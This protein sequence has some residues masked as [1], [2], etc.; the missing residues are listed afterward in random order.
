MR[1]TETVA[2]RPDTALVFDPDTYV[3]GVPYDAFARLRSREPVTWVEEPP[4][5]RWPAGPGYWAVW[6]HA[7]V[8]S[9]LSDPDLFSS[10]LGATQIRDPRT[11]ED[12]AYVRQS[13]LNMDPPG[14]SRLRG[15][16][17]RSFT[18][19]AVARLERR[20]DEQARR[21]VDGVAEAGECDFAKV[22]ADLPLSTLAEVLGV[23]E[24][25]RYLL[26]D[27]AS[28]VIGYQDAEYAAIDLTDREGATPMARAALAVRPRPDPEGRMPDP[29]TRDG[30]PDLYAYAHELAAF[31]RRHPGEDVMSILLH[32]VDEGGGRVS[33]SEFENMFW[34]FAVAGNET[35][36]NGMPGGM[37]ALLTFPEERA[38]LA[39]D[40]GLLKTG[41]EEMLRWWTPVIHFRRTATRDCE[42]AGRPIRA[43]DKVVVYFASANR[44]EHV[45][46]EPDRFDAG[47]TPNDHLAF[48]YGAHFCL[49]AHLA[50]VQMR[51]LFGAVL[52][53]FQQIELAGEV[54]RLRS[55]FQNGIKHLPIRWRP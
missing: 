40:R 45:F 23:P 20:I 1:E 19:R 25:D 27:W 29:R 48:G 24:S 37:F 33:V 2:E 42:L 43:G 22:A 32:Q 17:A 47:R 3:R 4:V 50:R 5:D 55:N 11:P 30:I 26:F 6:R 54:V 10:H 7:D 21:I 36:R 15:L 31:K 35:L 16:L 44:D 46:P 49:G 38:K 12:L 53:R 39:A 13:M 28:R 9:V 14:H 41:V 52:D 8:K 18:P 34:L 51:A